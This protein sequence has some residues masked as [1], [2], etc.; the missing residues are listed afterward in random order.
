M[1]GRFGNSGNYR[2]RSRSRARPKTTGRSGKGNN[3]SNNASKKKE[4]KFAVS[5][6]E[7][8]SQCMVHAFYIRILHS[9]D[10]KTRAL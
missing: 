10:Y 7:N 9:L 8:S 1:G 5:R 6:H 3:R 2:G 4:C